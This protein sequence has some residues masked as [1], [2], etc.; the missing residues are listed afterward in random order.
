MK[1]EQIKEAVQ[2]GK[3]VH[4]SNTGYKVILSKTYKGEEQWLIS[5]TNGHAIGLTWTDG[6]TMNG[7]EEDFYIASTTNDNL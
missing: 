4:W 5:H 1:L 3:T 2:Q 7:K 6:I